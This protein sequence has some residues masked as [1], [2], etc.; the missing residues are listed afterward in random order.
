[1]C[2]LCDATILVDDKHQKGWVQQ[3]IKS[4]PDQS[5]VN[6]SESRPTQSFIG[7]ALANA[8]AKTR[9]SKEFELNLTQV[10]FQ[11]GIPI[12]ELYMYELEKTNSTTIM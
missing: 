1:M 3:H 4:A 11:A 9:A 8:E 7:D 5:L 2:D 12:F 6:K 10:L